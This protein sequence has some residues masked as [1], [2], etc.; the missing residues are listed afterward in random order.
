[1]DVSDPL[2]KRGLHEY[3]N[4]TNEV[5]GWFRSSLQKRLH[6]YT[7]ATNEVGGWFRSFLAT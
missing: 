2:Y 5:G 7:N 3:T 4:A 1:V 6:E